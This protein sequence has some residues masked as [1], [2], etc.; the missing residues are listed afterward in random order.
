V[1]NLGNRGLG[2]TANYTFSHSLDNISST[3][4]DG[5]ESLY[6]LGYVDAFNPR[7]NYGNS[8]FDIRHRFNVAATW[9]IPWLKSAN[10]AF[11]RTA[12]GGWGMGLIYNVRSGLPFSIFDSNGFNGQN[13]P[14]WAPAQVVARSASPVSP[15]GVDAVGNA[16]LFNY[17]QLPATAGS[18]VGLGNALGIPNCTGLY[19]VG[20]SY[21]INGG[22]YPDRNQFSS[23]G[24]W[25]ADM[26]FYKTFKLTERFGLQF[27]AELY[28]ILN[29]HNQYVYV[30]NLDAASLVA[31]SQGRYFVQTEKGGPTGVAGTASDERRNVQFGLKLMF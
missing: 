16:N 23:P 28:N 8:D 14:L 12:F 6:G 25:N 20:C 2:L 29:H 15:T 26:N 3:F 9:D 4:T 11:V 31:D 5:Y 7:L 13:Y 30:Y 27:R 24:Y 18:V 17:I 1:T 22:S 19:H 21:A 10:N